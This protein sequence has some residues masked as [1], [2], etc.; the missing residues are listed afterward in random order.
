[1]AAPGSRPSATVLPFALCFHPHS[2][3]AHT[4][5]GG[6]VH[7]MRSVFPGYRGSAAIF[8]SV[9]PPRKRADQVRMAHSPST[10]SEAM[11][12][13]KLLRSPLP[14]CSD[15]LHPPSATRTS[16]QTVSGR[17]SHCPGPEGQD[18][19]ERGAKEK[20]GRALGRGISEG[21][22]LNDNQI[23]VSGWPQYIPQMGDLFVAQ[24][25]D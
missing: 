24:V 23:I 11:G 10:R 4:L 7:R 14:R 17:S 19:R 5:F 20:P 6:S 16:F 22:R 18:R 15:Q 8:A 2:R 21:T 3:G 13:R 25:D 1:V 9:S 12:P